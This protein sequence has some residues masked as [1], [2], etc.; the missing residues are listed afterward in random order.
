L[1]LKI[2][3]NAN[4]KEEKGAYG[5]GGVS[6]TVAEE[7]EAA[8]V[9]EVPMSVV[10]FLNAVEEPLKDEHL[11]QERGK[12]I[13]TSLLGTAADLTPEQNVKVSRESLA[14]H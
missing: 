9:E 4:E 2:D 12:F 3:E 1:L 8:A 14:C 13:Y 10:E 6:T 5:D 11:P 7:D